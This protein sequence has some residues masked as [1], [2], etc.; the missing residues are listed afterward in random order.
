MDYKP[1]DPQKITDT[2]IALDVAFT[3][4]MQ[5]LSQHD[6][7]LAQRLAETLSNAEKSTPD[8]LP[9]VRDLLIDWIAAL[10]KQPTH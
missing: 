4:L 9:G 2:V 3:A 6:A 10:P 7:A 1:G 5:S 8:N